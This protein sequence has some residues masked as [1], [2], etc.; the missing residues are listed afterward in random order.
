MFSHSGSD[1]MVDAGWG[2]RLAI[3]YDDRTVDVP[4]ATRQNPQHQPCDVCVS[5]I[6]HQRPDLPTRPCACI[7][8]HQDPIQ[9]EITRTQL[10]IE[11][12]DGTLHEINAKRAAL[13]ARREGMERAARLAREAG[14]VGAA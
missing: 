6:S 2:P 5:W 8:H 11:A 9:A 1:V 4:V 7:C 3:A 14:L 12:L 13:V 10:A